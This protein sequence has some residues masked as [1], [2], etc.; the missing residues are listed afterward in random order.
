VPVNASR[1]RP[2]LLAQSILAAAGL[3]VGTAGFTQHVPAAAAWWIVTG[4][5][6]VNF[7][8]GFYLQGLV[9]PLSAPQ[10]ARG[11]ELVPADTQTVTTRDGSFTTLTTPSEPDTE[12]F[13]VGGAMGWTQP[14]RH[15]R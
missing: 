7:G 2:V 3:V 6:A 9:T 8:L 10:D 4:I 1:P 5:A 13:D 12:P 15:E 11:V 14:P